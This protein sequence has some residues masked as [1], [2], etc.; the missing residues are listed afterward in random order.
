[1][2]DNL[3]CIWFK[4]LST[5]DQTK[6]LITILSNEIGNFDSFILTEIL[7][8]YNLIDKESIIKR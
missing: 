2:M 5:F 8:E 3:K 4:M 6:T 1:M 7:I